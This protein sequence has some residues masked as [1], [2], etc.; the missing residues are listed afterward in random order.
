MNI[1]CLWFSCSKNSY[2]SNKI[3][4]STTFC[5]AGVGLEQEEEGGRVQL[6][7][8]RKRLNLEKENGVG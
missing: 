8:E 3:L 1:Q 6:G 2:F 4:K 5:A 7:C